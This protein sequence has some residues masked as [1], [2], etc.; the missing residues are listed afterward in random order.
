M[1]TPVSLGF[2]LRLFEGSTAFFLAAWQWLKNSRRAVRYFII[3][4]MMQFPPRFRPAKNSLEKP[5]APAAGGA[6]L[7]STLRIPVPHMEVR[8]E[9]EGLEPG[10]NRAGQHTVQPLSG[11][12]T[13]LIVGEASNNRQFLSRT[14]RHHVHCRVVEA[15]GIAEGRYLAVVEGKIHLLLLDAAG[16]NK[17]LEFAHWF[18]SV[19]PEAKMLV[20]SDSL[21]ELSWETGVLEQVLMA[22]PFTPNELVE[23]VR[24]ILT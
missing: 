16:T 4:I 20:A 9:N 14:I 17:D 15:P 5:A 6:M 1:F 12:K 13:V 18:R 22:K 10:K 21:W 3:R 19:W 23:R 11:T 24:R 2:D 8:T 7:E